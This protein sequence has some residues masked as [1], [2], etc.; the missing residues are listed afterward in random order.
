M[1][2]ILENFLFTDS[3]MR[4]V[5]IRV[6]TNVNDAIHVKIEVVKLRYLVLLDNFTEAGI[7]FTKPS[8]EFWDTHFE[9]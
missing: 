4:I 8:V 6:G 2:N 7:P 9:V 1:E 5:V 3:E